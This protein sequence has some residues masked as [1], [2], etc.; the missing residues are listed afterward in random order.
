MFSCL[1]TGATSFSGIWFTKTMLDSG[2]ECIAVSRNTESHSEI[3]QNRLNWIRKDYPNFKLSTLEESLDISRVD[4][5]CFHGTATFDYRNP[6]FD[7]DLA[8]QSTLEV[9][10]IIHSKFKDALYVHTGTFSEPNESIGNNSLSFNP[11]STSKNII[12]NQHKSLV[13]EGQLLKYVMPNPFGPLEN[14]KFT[15]YLIQQWAAGK[16]PLI[17]SPNYVRD[18]VPIDLLSAH[19]VQTLI[20]YTKG[21]GARTAWPSKYI[22]SNLA[23]AKR[24]A[25]HFNAL[26][27]YPTPI[28]AVLHHEFE[29]PRIRINKDYCEDTVKGWSE[30]DSWTKIIEEAAERFAKFS[31]ES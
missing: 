14:H 3:V 11:Y 1:I 19:Y 31:L 6:H 25:N 21:L 12:Y 18:N 17:K 13:D 24:Y 23:F 10:K 29:E 20:N 16:K 28:D 2:I 30:I 9:S 22:E 7:I 5:V 4:V 15:G 27:G 8:V 26:T